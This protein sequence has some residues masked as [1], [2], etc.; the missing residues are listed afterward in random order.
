MLS[1]TRCP[2]IRVAQMAVFGAGMGLTQAPAT[3]AIMGAVPKH[4]A[5]VGSA[6]NDATRLFGGTL[7]V[8]VIGS[9]A[10]SLH[11][12][13]LAA[14]LPAGLPARA[15]TAVRGSV[16]GAVIAAQK[17][18]H[19]GFAQPGSR[20]KDTA[21]LAFLHS[22]S[23]GC[24]VAGG[25]AA[26]GSSW[27]SCSCPPGSLGH[28]ARRPMKPKRPVSC[29]GCRAPGSVLIPAPMEAMSARNR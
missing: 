5:G 22:F 25:V 10:A 9:V 20:L 11:T 16:G 14:T 15:I 21:I 19:A 29:P 18:S 17:A 2:R 13:R 28:R 4:K 24:L 6:V 7:G 27:Q 23:G 8:A 1:R 3:E 26:A 12:S